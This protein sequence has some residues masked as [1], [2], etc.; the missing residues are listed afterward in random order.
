MRRVEEH[1]QMSIIL[2]RPPKRQQ[3]QNGE[4][5]FKEAHQLQAKKPVQSTHWGGSKALLFLTDDN[6]FNL[7]YILLHHTALVGNPAS[8]NAFQLKSRGLDRAG[9]SA[10]TGK[11]WRFI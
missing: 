6:S 4:T 10:V 5:A 7:V 11:H 1:R 3:K 2:S 8:L 9:N